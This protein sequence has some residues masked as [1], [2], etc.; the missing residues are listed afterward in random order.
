MEICHKYILGEQKAYPSCQF[1]VVAELKDDGV[2]GTT[3]ERDDFK[4]L[5]KLIE[6]QKA[7]ALCCYYG[8]RRH[9]Y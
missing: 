8:K 3:F 4:E 7:C 5:I 2:S 6:G 9:L 1:K